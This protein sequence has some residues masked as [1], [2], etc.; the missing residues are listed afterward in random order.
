MGG[1]KRKNAF[2]KKH[3]VFAEYGE[4]NLYQPH[5]L[6]NAPQLI[7]IHNNVKI[8]AD[9]T[10][11]EHD[12]INGMLSI[13]DGKPYCIH[14]SCIE[15]FDNVF[16]G[17]NSTIIGNCVIGPNAIIAAGSVVS[18]DVPQG[19][20]VAGNPA[21]VIGN[22]DDFHQKRIEK[23]GEEK[24]YDPMNRIDKLWNDFYFNNTK[25]QP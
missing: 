11:Y 10:F 25:V 20:I 15:I 22:F 19:T 6:P 21:K 8:A 9:V 18:K 5:K 1:I 12:A 4:Y 17:G 16:I 2:I 3:N 7:K 23:D 24:I 14:G 13:M